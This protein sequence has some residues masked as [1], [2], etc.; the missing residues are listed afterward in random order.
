M[1]S[2]GKIQNMDVRIEN[3]LSALGLAIVFQII[4]IILSVIAKKPLFAL[5]LFEQ[6]ARPFLTSLN[7]KLN[8]EGRSDFALAIRGFIA[9]TIVFL[10]M[11]GVSYGIN[12]IMPYIGYHQYSHVVL[13]FLVLSPIL[14]ARTAYAV[15]VEK[16]MDGAYLQLSQTLNQNLIPADKHGLRR[17][18][19]KSVTLS[20]IEFVIAPLLFYMVG[21]IIGAYFYVSLSLFIRLSGQNKR[22]FTSVFNFLYLFAK[23]IS[24]IFGVFVIFVSSLLSAGGRP[25]RVVQSFKKPTNMMEGAMAYAQNITLGGSFQNRVGE[26]IKVDWLGPDSATA[27]LTHKDVLRVVI[28]YI[29]SIFLVVVVLYGLLIYT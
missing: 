17:A 16:P 13:L 25:L 6:C 18:A 24:S 27:K 8:R 3:A 11:C 4:L 14:V 21:G 29:I 7:D 5:P 10:M 12:F 1:A 2:C 19:C 23:L 22:A 15:S 28:Q 20:L 9:F 26:T